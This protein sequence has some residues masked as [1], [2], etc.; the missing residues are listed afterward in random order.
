[1]VKLK[2]KKI[3]ILGGTFDPAH[4]GH[5]RISIEAKKKFKLKRIIWAITKKNPFK[6]KSSNS[7]NQRIKFSEKF[8]KQTKFI[9]VK[10]FDDL[11]K[12]SRAYELISYYLKKN[13][14]I[15]LYFL[16]GAD[17]LIDFHKWYKWKKILEK[18]NVIVFDR[19]K[20]KSKSLRS[21]AFKGFKNKG[22][23]FVNYKRV[24]ISSSKLRK[25]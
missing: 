6:K 3:G 16:M 9:K 7:L 19:Y 11:V 5:L 8:S 18:C 20:Y 15:E 17:C 14:N 4:L 24:N 23:K 22:I 2:K 13:R 1:M 25:I 21:P 10:Y 12:S